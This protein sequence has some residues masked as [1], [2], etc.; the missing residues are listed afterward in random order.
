MATVFCDRPQLFWGQESHSAL[1][2]TSSSPNKSF[3]ESCLFESRLEALLEVAAAFERATAAT[4][5]PSSSP[6]NDRAKSAWK[7]ARVRPGPRSW[8]PL[9]RKIHRGYF[10][11]T[12]G[13]VLADGRFLAYWPRIFLSESQVRSDDV[14]FSQ[15]ASLGLLRR[16]FVHL[17]RRQ[18]AFNFSS[19]RVI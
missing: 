4:V 7:T 15:A 2:K 11:L 18:V 10:V 17:G 12:G 1:F 6:R 5:F 13:G 14:I 16:L 3:F 19:Y 8:R 9:I